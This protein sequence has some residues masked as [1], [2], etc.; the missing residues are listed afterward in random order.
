[1][2][3]GNPKGTELHDFPTKTLRP[4]HGI[5]FKEPNSTGKGL[6]F[7]KSDMGKAGP[8]LAVA[9]RSTLQSI[10]QHRQVGR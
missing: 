6:A 5:L 8:T 2:D 10:A 7:R 3:R 4:R 1:M 9:C